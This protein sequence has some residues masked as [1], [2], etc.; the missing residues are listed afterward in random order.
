LNTLAPKAKEKIHKHSSKILDAPNI[1]CLRIV[2]PIN[3]VPLQVNWKDS[4]PLQSFVHTQ[5]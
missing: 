5:I 1:Y 4:I 3:K 2:H